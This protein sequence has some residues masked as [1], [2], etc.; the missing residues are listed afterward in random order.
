VSS[1]TRYEKI[2]EAYKQ[3]YEKKNIK[4]RKMERANP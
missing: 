1:C 4:S 2:D 3:L